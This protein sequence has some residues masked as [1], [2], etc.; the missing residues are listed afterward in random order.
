[1][2]NG[3]ESS[4]DGAPRRGGDGEAEDEKLSDRYEIAAKKE[5]LKLCKQI[6]EEFGEKEEESV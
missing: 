3:G 6:T 5:L 4:G 1:M 2:G